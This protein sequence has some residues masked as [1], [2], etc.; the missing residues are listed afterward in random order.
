[1][2]GFLVI[3]LLIVLALLSFSVYFLRY[4]AEERR[5]RTVRI[6]VALFEIGSVGGLFFL[7]STHRTDGWDNSLIF[8]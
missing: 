2:P 6:G 1:M 4:L 3:F 5:L 8:L 7:F